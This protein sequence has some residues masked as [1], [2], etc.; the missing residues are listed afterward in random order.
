[1]GFNK[2]NSPC[3]KINRSQYCSVG[4]YDS[5]VGELEVGVPQG[6]CLGPLLFLIYINDLPKTTQGNV[7][8][9]ADDTSLCHTSNDISKLES[10]TNEDLELLDNWLKG[11]KLSLNVA[12]TKSMLICTKSRRKILNSNDDKL[13]LLIRDRELESIDVIKYLGVHVYS[14]S[15]KEHLKSVTSKVPRGMGMLQ[16]AKYYFPEACLKAHYSSIVEPYFRYCCS[17]WGTCG[18]TETNGKFDA[19]CRPL[20]ERIGWKTIEELITEES[21]TIV[22]KSLHGLAPQYLCHFFTRNSAGE[23]RTL[24]NTSTDLKIPKKSSVN[25][26]RCF[27]YRGV[28]LWNS[29]ST[30]AKRAHTLGTFKT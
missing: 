28:K 14:L 27:S 17:V 23:A 18:V 9:Y 29:L 26:Q 25:E 8:M 21:K 5:N 1:M 4:G 20:I 12:K 19:S 16:Q 10:A 6:S 13:N 7:S 15:W 30:E 3:S 22:Y 11:N 24:R 2:G